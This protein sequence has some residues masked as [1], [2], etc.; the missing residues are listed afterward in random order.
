MAELVAPQAVA[1]VVVD[2]GVS[3]S[4]SLMAFKPNR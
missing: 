3:T 2:V 4:T 1:L